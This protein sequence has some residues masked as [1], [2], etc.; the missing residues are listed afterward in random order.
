MPIASFSETSNTGLAPKATGDF[1]PLFGLRAS[2][3]VTTLGNGRIALHQFSTRHLYL[4]AGV[5]KAK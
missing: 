4:V 3:R 5:G 2:G 1:G